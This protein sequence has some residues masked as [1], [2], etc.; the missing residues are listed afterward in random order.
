MGRGGRAQKENRGSLAPPDSEVE[1][2][3]VTYFTQEE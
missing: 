2:L 3:P 1:L